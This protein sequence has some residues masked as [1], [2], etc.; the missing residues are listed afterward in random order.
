AERLLDA[1]APGLAHN[2]VMF[3]N[4]DGQPEF[5]WHVE[6]RRARRVSVQFDARQIVDRVLRGSDKRDD[7]LQPPLAERNFEGRS[8]S[9]SK[10]ADA[11]NIGEKQVLKALV[12]GDVKEDRSLLSA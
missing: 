4:A 5:K 7:A 3:A 10:S 2:P 12:V 11:R 8:G 6:P 9:K 1:M